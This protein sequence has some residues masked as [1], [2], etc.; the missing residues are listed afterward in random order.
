MKENIEL[1]KEHKKFL[2]NNGKIDN[3]SNSSINNLSLSNNAKIINKNK[4]KYHESSLKN[5]KKNN[6]LLS[7][8]M[9]SQ[10]KNV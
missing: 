4:T 9:I 1:L 5:E 3:I 6:N 8:N 2:E 7:K 10:T